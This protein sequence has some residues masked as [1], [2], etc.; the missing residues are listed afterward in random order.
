MRSIG[1]PPTAMPTH[2]C[3]APGGSTHRPCAG[4]GGGDDPMTML[5]EAPAFLAFLHSP[6]QPLAYARPGDGYG[7]Y[8]IDRMSR[9]VI[10]V[11]GPFESEAQALRAGQDRVAERAAV[12][13]AQRTRS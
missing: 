4:L 10:H 12:R 13:S 11:R 5:P 8:L 3:P 7:W 1:G 2:A 6:E 9:C